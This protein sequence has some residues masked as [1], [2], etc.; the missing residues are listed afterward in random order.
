[1]LVNVIFH[2]VYGHIYRMAE[3][4]AEGGA[5]DAV[6]GLTNGRC[7]AILY[8]Y[9]VVSSTSNG[10]DPYVPDMRLHAV[11]EVRRHNRGRSLHRLQEEGRPVH[12]QIAALQAHDARPAMRG[13][14]RRYAP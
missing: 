9:L 12:L 8:K 6:S 1:M 10:G 11:Q 4:V 2:S 5:I 14:T 3:A 7:R 13:M